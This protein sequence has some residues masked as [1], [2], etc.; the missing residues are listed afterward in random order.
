MFTIGMFS[1]CMPLMLIAIIYG[2]S[3][4]MHS[5]INDGSNREVP[6]AQSSHLLADETL[7]QLSL[8]NEKSVFYYG[9]EI[10]GEDESGESTALKLRPHFR[11]SRDEIPIPRLTVY[12]RFSRPPPL[13]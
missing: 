13:G 10:V 4:G 11:Q 6:A 5:M 2:A 12:T 8:E 1:T 9:Q 3:L 7:R